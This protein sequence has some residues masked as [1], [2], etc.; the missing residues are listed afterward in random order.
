MDQDT[1][2]ALMKAAF[3]K[4]KQ[5]LAVKETVSEVS[6]PFPRS[7]KAYLGGEAASFFSTLISKLF[8]TC[9]LREA[10]TAACFA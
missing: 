10:P 7:R 8:N 2:Q 5:G 6:Y 3:P 1:L 9:S 4:G